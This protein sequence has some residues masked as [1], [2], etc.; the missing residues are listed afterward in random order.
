MM[1]DALERISEV[2]LGDTETLLSDLEQTPVWVDKT[3]PYR[4]E[5]DGTN[6]RLQRMASIEFNQAY[7]IEKLLTFDRICLFV[8]RMMNESW[9]KSLD[10]EAINKQPNLSVID[11]KQAVS[12]GADPGAEWYI[13]Q[14]ENGIQVASIYKEQQQWEFKIRE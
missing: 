3:T 9:A 10:P 12:L 14:L 5:Y 6:W 13:A 8:T 4:L 7:W 2:D 11:E 1:N